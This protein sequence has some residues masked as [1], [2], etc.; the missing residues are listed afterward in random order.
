MEGDFFWMLKK[1][2]ASREVKRK[3]KL[4]RGLFENKKVRYH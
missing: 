3:R 1:E 4:L 2:N